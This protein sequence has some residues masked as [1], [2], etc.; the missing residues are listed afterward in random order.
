MSSNP[1]KSPPISAKEV[2]KEAEAVLMKM[3]KEGLTAKQAMNIN[4]NLLEEVYSLAYS[5]YDQ[6][7]YKEALS[8]FQLL[9]GASPN[10]YRY[11]LGFASCYHQLND[12]DNA[13]CGFSLAQ[14]LDPINPTPAYYLADCFIKRELIPEAKDFLHLSIELCGKNEKHKNLKEKAELILQTINQNETSKS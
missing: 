5:N 7:K 11:V 4:E 9:T 10:E 8:L 12:I 1:K 13:I 2:Q 6:G 14:G 3:H